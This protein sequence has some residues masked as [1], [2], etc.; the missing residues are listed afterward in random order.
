MP[1]CSSGVEHESL[2][3]M[4]ATKHVCMYVCTHD[5][6]TAETPTGPGVEE[7]AS[8]QAQVLPYPT[9]PIRP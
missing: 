9:T 4:T 7:A 5:Q 2:F 8:G 1:A 6:P 3:W